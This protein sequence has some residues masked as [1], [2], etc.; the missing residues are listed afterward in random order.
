MANTRVW[1]RKPY[2][3]IQLDTTTV[4][5]NLH[6]PDLLVEVQDGKDALG[7]ERWKRVDTSDIGEL[8]LNYIMYGLHAR[9]GE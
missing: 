1:L 6:V 5:H 2:R 4:V 7:V 3:V 9:N 8:E